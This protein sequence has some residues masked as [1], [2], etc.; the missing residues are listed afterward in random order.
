MSDQNCAAR[1]E[2]SL[3]AN[4]YFLNVSRLPFHIEMDATRPVDEIALFDHEFIPA[5]LG[6]QTQRAVMDQ[7]TAERA[8]CAARRGI[9]RNV[10]C[11]SEEARVRTRCADV[12]RLT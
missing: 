3:P 6:F 7:V 10:V 8:A 5:I 11:R 12:E 9:F 2:H 1:D 4:L